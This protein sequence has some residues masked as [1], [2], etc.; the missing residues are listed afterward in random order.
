MV[1]RQSSYIYLSS[2]MFQNIHFFALLIII[3]I[4]VRIVILPLIIITTIKIKR[5]I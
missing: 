4:I 3:T 1:E 2:N 5:S